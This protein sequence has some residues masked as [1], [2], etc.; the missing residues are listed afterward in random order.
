MENDVGYFTS[1]TVCRLE[2]SGFRYPPEARNFSFPRV[3][4]I[5]P[6][7]HIKPIMITRVT[8]PG[9]KVT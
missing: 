2:E 7:S 3:F 9:G 5:G 4:Q 8:F 1:C 6:R